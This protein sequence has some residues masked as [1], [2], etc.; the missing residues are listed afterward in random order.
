MLPL[1]SLLVLLLFSF[2]QK[3]ELLLHSAGDED[4]VEAKK[5]AAKL[6]KA[7]AKAEAKAAATAAAAA[8]V[9][10]DGVSIG[11]DQGTATGDAAKGKG[12][13]KSAFGEQ[14]PHWSFHVDKTCQWGD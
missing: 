12:K 4:T 2:K 5:K 11:G 8:V 1:Q 10:A 9:T 7:Q 6:A 3:L 14:L 13:G